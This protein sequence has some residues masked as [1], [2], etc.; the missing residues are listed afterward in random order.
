M[1]AD[2]SERLQSVLRLSGELD[3]LPFKIEFANFVGGPAILE[4][5]EPVRLI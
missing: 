2:Q 4:A 1:V 5:F 3:K